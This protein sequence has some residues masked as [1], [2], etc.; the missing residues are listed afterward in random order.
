MQDATARLQLP[1]AGK[2]S[3]ERQA[4]LLTLPNPGS[5]FPMLT[6]RAPLGHGWQPRRQ[7]LPNSEFPHVGLPHPKNFQLA[8][9]EEFRGHCF[10]A[11]QGCWEETGP[12]NPRAPAL[13]VVYFSGCQSNRNNSG[14]LKPLNT[15]AQQTPT[16]GRQ[17]LHLDFSYFFPHIPKSIF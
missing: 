14:C 17:T 1:E 12:L 16:N 5:S 4:I 3:R 13:G 11:G 10:Q 8:I 9:L 6:G 2:S 15:T 7:S